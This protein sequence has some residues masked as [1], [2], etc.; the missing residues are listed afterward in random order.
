VSKVAGRSG[1]RWRR[2]VTFFRENHPWVCSIC[3]GDIPKDVDHQVDPQGHTLHHDPPLSKLLAEGLDPYN[4][5][6]LSPAHRSCNSSLG[7]DT[8]ARQVR[9]SRQW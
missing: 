9:V 8:E 5:D 1:A 2:V 4:H 7:D 6:F 3:G